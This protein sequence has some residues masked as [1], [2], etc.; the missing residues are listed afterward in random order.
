MRTQPQTQETTT[1]HQ[2]RQP[3]QGHN[4]DYQLYRARKKREDA[5]EREEKLKAHLYNTKQLAQTRTELRKHII[6]I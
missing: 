6:T 2:I 1:G 4:E 3:T 5:Q